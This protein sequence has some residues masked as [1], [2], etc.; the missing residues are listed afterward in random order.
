[1]EYLDVILYILKNNGIW[2][3]LGPLHYHST[4]TIK[5]SYSQFLEILTI[6][7]FEV[8]SQNKIEGP[9]GCDK[10][11]NMKPDYYIVPFDVFRKTSDIKTSDNNISTNF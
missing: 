1:M 4:S 2:I 10:T 9:Y 6:L 8:L 5:Y 3:N 7:G 11:F